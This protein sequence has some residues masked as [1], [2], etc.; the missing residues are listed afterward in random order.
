[1]SA[2]L[3]PK[4]FRVTEIFSSLQGEGP[5]MGEK[6][7]FIRFEACHMT[8]A[9]CD[10]S[11]RRGRAMS[12]EAI[13]RK[14]DELEKSKGPH[15]CVSLT[16]GEPLLYADL[17]KPLCR[18]LKKRKYRIL[19]ETSGV[20]GGQ[21]SKVIGE[22]DIIA[23]DLKLASMTRQRDFLEAHRRFLGIAKKK[24]LYLKVVVSKA[25]D[26]RELNRHLRM[27]AAVAPKVPVFLQPLSRPGKAYPDPSLMRYLFQLQRIGAKR[28][29]GLRVGIQLHKVLNI[30]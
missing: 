8:C 28:L 30:R 23:M 18:A 14:T 21:L 22:C 5:R 19:L 27:A 12:L 15:A 24:E 13:L 26:I 3:S 2:V 29:P 6:H 11:S 20:L 16:G 17:L 25:V 4:T 9:Y 7:L 1:M 10:E